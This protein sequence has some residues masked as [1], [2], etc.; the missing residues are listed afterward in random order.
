MIDE[1]GSIFFPFELAGEDEKVGAGMVYR[2]MCA[3]LVVQWKVEQ[4][5]LNLSMTPTV[6]PL[7]YNMGV[8]KSGWNYL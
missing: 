8:G 4:D 7:G 1:R 5:G 6:R 2:A 3:G